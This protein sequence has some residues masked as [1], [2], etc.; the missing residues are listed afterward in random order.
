MADPAQSLFELDN[1][2]IKALGARITALAADHLTGMRGHAAFAPM[3]AEVRRALIEQPLPRQGLAPDLI[4]ERIA[5]ELMPYPMGNG[6][7]RFFGW[8][9]SPPAHLA[10]LTEMLAAALN[11]SCAGGD[12]AA[13]YLEHGV[14]CWLMDL[15]D[16][17]N[18]R[19][20]GLLVG[21]APWRP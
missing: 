17:P 12:H 15:L 18:D 16:F 14:V 10:A 5:T 4:L 7:P 20:Y 3:R 21:G 6:H 11:A 19:S 1:D 13:I 2:R 8:V 9:N